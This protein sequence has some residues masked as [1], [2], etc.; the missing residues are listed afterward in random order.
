M[1]FGPV[2]LDQAAGAVL[3]HS[4]HLPDG[5]LAK[6]R[7]LTGDDTARLHAAGIA[8]VTVARLEAG[9]VPEDDAARALAQALVPDPAGQGLRLSGAGAGRVN[10]LSDGPGLLDIDVAA[11]AALN[12]VDPMITLATL[13][14]LKRVTGGTMV[15]TVKI[16]SYAVPEGR[17]ATACDVA[18]AAMRRVPPQIASATLIETRVGDSAPP[19]KGRRAMADRLARLDARL[20]PRVVVPHD[21][22]ALARAIES[23][24]G[25]MVLVLTASATSDVADVAP[26]ALRRAGG[27]VTRFGMPVDP[28][29]LLFL[30]RMGDARPVIGLPGC[31]RSPALNGADWVLERVLCGLDVTSED[32]TAM[33][34]GGLLKEMPTRPRPRRAR[35]NAA[36]AK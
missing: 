15:G 25:D 24:P 27:Q 11:V 29:N 16:I 31:A 19:D 13:P 10:L 26:A 28:G 23:A 6:G 32:I 1:R 3:A 21:E 5:K 18:R 17:L 34:V 8:E 14:P 22:P 9:D 36:N 2:S 12:R 35:E 33:G 20:T 30:G 7:V 4:L